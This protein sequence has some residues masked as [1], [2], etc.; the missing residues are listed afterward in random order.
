MSAQVCV[1]MLCVSAVGW[2][3]DVCTVGQTTARGS[4]ESKLEKRLLSST[5][6]VASP[7]DY[8]EAAIVCPYLSHLLMLTVT[9]IN[10]GAFSSLSFTSETRA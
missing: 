9:I 8:F 7:Q 10:S 4:M 6:A 3:G 5:L 1:C 2:K